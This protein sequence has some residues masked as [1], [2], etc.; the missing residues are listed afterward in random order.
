[1]PGQL[2]ERTALTT[3]HE[4]KHA[5]HP[6]FLLAFATFI[7]FAGFLVWNLISTKQSQKTGGNTSGFGGPNDPMA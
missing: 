1:M 5:M 2:V 4:R 3:G 7:L 6:L